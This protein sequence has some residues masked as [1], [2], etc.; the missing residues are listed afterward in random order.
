M[1]SNIN[2]G[3]WENPKNW[4]QYGHEGD[5]YYSYEHNYWFQLKRDGNPAENNWFFPKKPEH[6][7]IWKFAGAVGAGLANWMASV[8]DTNRLDQMSIPGTNESCTGYGGYDDHNENITTQRHKLSD[9]FDSG[10]RFIDIRC[11]VEDNDI[12][13]NHEDI[14]LNIKLNGV[15]M[16]CKKFLEEHPLE[17]ILISIKQE[18]SNLKDKQ[19][20]DKFN[21]ITHN[22]FENY[23]YKSHDGRIPTLAE[24]RGKAVIISNIA[25]LD[26]IKWD[27]MVVEDSSQIIANNYNASDIKLKKERIYKNIHDSVSAHLGSASIE[28]IFLTVTSA[29]PG[30]NSDISSFNVNDDGSPFN[31]YELAHTINRYIYN[32]LL[33]GIKNTPCSAQKDDNPYWGIVVMDFPLD[34]KNQYDLPASIV[35]FNDHAAI[36]HIKPVKIYNVCYNNYI[37]ASPHYE[38]RDSRKVLGWNKEKVDV[39]QGV[40]KIV[41][42]D[43]MRVYLYN[44]YYKELMYATEYLESDDRIVATWTHGLHNISGAD[45]NFLWVY[46]MLPS[47]GYNVLLN[48][49]HKSWLREINT[50]DADDSRR[51]VCGNHELVKIKDK[52]NPKKFKIIKNKNDE[53]H[54]IIK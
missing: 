28:K 43:L 51:M 17:T 18:H 4:N 39:E 25:G 40:W 19:F 16:E 14:Y 44:T 33:D 42:T 53:K 3:L 7:N 8:P 15:L 50:V 52:Y 5:I 10:I 49:K 13:I 30:R 47:N 35:K 37:Y 41:A 21:K 48:F 9:Q 2:E 29:T 26:G 23:L 45:E 12:Q 1:V 20:A 36:K 31:V 32:I 22:N 27:E 54:F 24:V 38:D 46:A 6:N 11:C 34:M